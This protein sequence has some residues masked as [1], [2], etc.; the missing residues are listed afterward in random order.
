MIRRCIFATIS[1]TLMIMTA[2]CAQC[3]KPGAHNAAASEAPAT[4][5]LDESVDLLFET[6]HLK[7]VYEETIPKELDKQIAAN[8]NLAVLRPTMEEFFNKYMGWRSIGPELKKLYMEKFSKEEIDAMIVF[9][10]TPVGQ[11]SARLTSEIMAKSGEIGQ[12][13][14]NDNIQELQAM[15][16]ERLRRLSETEPEAEQETTPAAVAE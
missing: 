10:R 6:I 7:E 15:M 1:L 8:P 14:V 16:V 4:A 13:M 5:G 3:P 11:K 9:Y 2:A 12:K